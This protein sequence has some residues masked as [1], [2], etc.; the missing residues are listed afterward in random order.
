MRHQ[1]RKVL[2]DKSGV[3]EIT[4]ILTRSDMVNEAELQKMCVFGENKSRP[5]F[6][7]AGAEA[8]RWNCVQQFEKQLE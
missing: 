7:F 4:F 8:V 2:L 1:G 5:K 3:G 6:A